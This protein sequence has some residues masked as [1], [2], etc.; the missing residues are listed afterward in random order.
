M[1]AR[2]RKRPPPAPTCPLGPNTRAVYDLVFTIL[3]F[4]GRRPSWREIAD[5]MGF[6]NPNSTTYH[7]NVLE[8]HGYIRRRNDGRGHTTPAAYTILKKP[9]GTPFRGLVAVD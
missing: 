5:R 4:E 6:T 3:T 1:P 8:K 7:M 9:D 2:T